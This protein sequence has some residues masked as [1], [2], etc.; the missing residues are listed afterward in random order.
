MTAEA[1]PLT[2]GAEFLRLIDA[3]DETGIA[4]LLAEDAQLVEE[5][6][7]RWVRG[8]EAIGATLR[9]QLSRIADIQSTVTDVHVERWG[10]VSTSTMRRATKW[11]QR[12]WSGAGLTGTGGSR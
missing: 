4:H 6:T 11:R 7:R 10:D 3:K 2:M 9:T 1:L 8:R 5:T 12:R